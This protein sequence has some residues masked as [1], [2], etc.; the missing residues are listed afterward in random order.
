MNVDAICFW[1]VWDV[2]KAIL[3]VENY[4]EAVVLSSQTAL[5]DIIGTHDLAE[6]LTKREQLG[7]RLREVLDK[8]TNPWGMTIQSV[9]IRDVVI[10]DA[11]QDA[12][13]KQAQAERERQAVWSAPSSISSS[14]SSNVSF[15]PSGARMTRITRPSFASASRRYIASGSCNLR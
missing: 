5:R 2:K 12:M 9:E 8:K 14:S 7:E 15:S 10:P 6:V 4:F 13:S 3:E 1:L 11:L